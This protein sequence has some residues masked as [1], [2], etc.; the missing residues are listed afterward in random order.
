MAGPLAEFAAWGGAGRAG[1]GWSAFRGRQTFDGA[2][3]RLG[4]AQIGLERGL[5]DQTAIEK[6]AQP[7]GI[8]ARRVY[9][10]LDQGRR[11]DPGSFENRNRR[12]MG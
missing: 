3:Q 1:F 9:P 8:G 7:I 10:A 12:G 4:A 6:S 2:E 11:T 5:G